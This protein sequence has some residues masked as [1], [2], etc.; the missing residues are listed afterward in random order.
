MVAITET[1][2]DHCWAIVGSWVID[3]TFP[4]YPMAESLVIAGLG[5]D[6]SHCFDFL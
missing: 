5:H 4:D 6:A 3:Q 2:H 1:F